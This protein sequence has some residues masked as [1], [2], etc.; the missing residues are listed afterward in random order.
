M[1][2][3]VMILNQNF[4]IAYKWQFDNFG[5]EFFVAD[6][7][8]NGVADLNTHRHTCECDGLLHGG[9]ECTTGGFTLAV[10]GFNCLMAAQNALVQ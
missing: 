4:A 10:R 9:A 8:L 6:D 5:I 1:A 7:D 3:M 2:G